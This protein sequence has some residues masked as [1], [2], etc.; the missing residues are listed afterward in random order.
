MTGHRKR[1]QFEFLEIELCALPGADPGG[2]QGVWTP[3]FVNIAKK[4]RMKVGNPRSGSPPPP[5]YIGIAI[6]LRQ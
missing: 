2:V 5:F 4:E 6:N 3:F 1:D